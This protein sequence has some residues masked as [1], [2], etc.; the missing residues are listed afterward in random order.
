VSRRKQ[1]GELKARAFALA[2]ALFPRAFALA[3]GLGGEKICREHTHLS[4]N[5]Y[6]T[7]AQDGVDLRSCTFRSD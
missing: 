6:F 5:G 3:K 2:C 4:G 1:C 7:L